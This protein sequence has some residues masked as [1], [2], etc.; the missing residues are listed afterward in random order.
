MSNDKRSSTNLNALAGLL[1]KPEIKGAWFNGK[2]VNL[3]GYRFISCRFDGC[4][5]LVASTN[6]VLENCFVDEKTN[7]VYGTEI[8]KVIQLYN[9]RYSW[10]YDHYPMFAPRKNS[11]GTISIGV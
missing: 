8:L 7:I 11:D 5:L 2:E 3:D 6:F 1:A 10:V 4:H 9:A